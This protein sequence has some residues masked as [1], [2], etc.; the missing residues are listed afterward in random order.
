MKGQK[1]LRLYDYDDFGNRTS[2]YET[3]KG[4]TNYS[5]N[6]LN[7]LISMKDDEGTYTYKYDKRG[8]LSESY[9]D[10]QLTHFYHFGEIN[11]LEAVLNYEQNL[12]A[13][14]EY[15]GL[16]H[17][18]KYSE[19]VPV[20]PLTREQLNEI[21]RDV[22]YNQL[23]FDPRKQIEDTI[24]LSKPYLNLLQRK[25]GYFDDKSIDAYKIEESQFT[26]DFSVLTVKNDDEILHYYHDDLGSPIRFINDREY[27]RGVLAFD[28][29]GKTVYQKG[30]QSISQPFRF[31]GYAN[32]EVAGN[33][34]LYAQAREYNSNTGRFIAQDTHWNTKNMIWGDD[35]YENYE[36]VVSAPDSLSIRQSN[37]LSGYTL[38][39]P[40]RFVDL[41]GKCLW[42]IPGAPELWERTKT[43]VTNG[44]NAVTNWA[45]ANSEQATAVGSGA[46]NAGVNA[47]GQVVNNAFFDDEREWWEI[48]WWEVTVSFGEGYLSGL[49]ST[50]F[51]GRPNQWQDP[52]RYQA[53]RIILPF[54]NFVTY[55]VGQV[56]TGGSDDELDF[57]TGAFFAMFPA[58]RGGGMG[59]RGFGRI[60]L[61]DVLDTLRGGFW[62]SLAG[63]GFN[64]GRD[65]IDF[66]RNLF[67]DDYE[68]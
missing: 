56:L 62:E 35:V 40:V 9:K 43:T 53:G 68:E 63:E 8:N 12:A 6:A 57:W 36:L 18:V 46:I 13:F 50:L 61:E 45:T 21:P 20:D 27:D 29:F 30:H 44:L 47:T 52:R 4:T 64:F 14:Y 28:E 15:N 51:P 19:H 10:E 41:D 25:T 34:V 65:V 7:Q 58:W 1:E 11:R 48:N 67:G 17:R 33:D 24:D 16:G 31:T 5:Y 26:Y 3:G 2:K 22:P 59:P 54:L 39:N 37:N 42:L 60:P 49:F 32:N 23:T 55:S 38:N 66:L